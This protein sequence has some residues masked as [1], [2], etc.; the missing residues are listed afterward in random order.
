MLVKTK[1]NHNFF[2]I[3][4]LPSQV[5]SVCTI[6]LLDVVEVV[7]AVA[8]VHSLLLLLSANFYQLMELLLKKIQYAVKQYSPHSIYRNQIIVHFSTLFYLNEK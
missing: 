1:P 8:V 6:A 7:D 3:K 2:T 4:L 5:I